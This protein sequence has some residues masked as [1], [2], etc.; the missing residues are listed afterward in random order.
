MPFHGLDQNRQQR[1]Q[2]LAQTRSDASNH[3]QCLT[4][5]VVVDP[6]PWMGPER[7][8]GRPPRSKGVACNPAGTRQGCRPFRRDSLGQYR[9]AILQNQLITCVAVLN[10]PTITPADEHRRGA[11]Q[12]RQRAIS[13]SIS[14]GAMRRPSTL[15]LHSTGYP[16]P[17]SPRGLPRDPTSPAVRRSFR[18]GPWPHATA[19]VIRRGSRQ[20]S[21]QER[22][23]DKTRFFS[24]RERGSPS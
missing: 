2:P 4:Y 19:S 21:V 15:S 7:W 24:E 16:S 5:L 22:Q 20:G 11:D 9:S 17:G 3:D 12:V 13:K 8:P 6:P 10:R 23:K 18:A 14:G 1:P